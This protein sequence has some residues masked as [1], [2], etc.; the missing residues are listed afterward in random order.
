V[1][2]L[3][4]LAFVTNSLHHVSE[5]GDTLDLNEQQGLLEILENIQMELEKKTKCK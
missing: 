5:N 2:E 4:Q 1:S 3:S